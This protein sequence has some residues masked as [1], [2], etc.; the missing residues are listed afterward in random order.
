MTAYMLTAG[1]DTFSL[2]KSGDTVDGKGGNDFITTG[3]GNY[4]I[5]LGGGADTV[6]T[7]TVAGNT[8]SIDAAYGD[9]A[10]SIG[11]GSYSYKG[12]VGTE[13]IDASRGGAGT[14]WTGDGD[15]VISVSG[16][17]ASIAHS[18]TAG[19]GRHIVSLGGAGKNTVALGDGGGQIDVNGS[20]SSDN[21][22]SVKEGDHLIRFTNGNQTISAGAGN[23]SIYYSGSVDSGGSIS[24][25]DGANLLA[26][27][28]RGGVIQT[29]NGANTVVIGSNVSDYSDTANGTAITGR[30]ADN[31]QIYG[32]TTATYLVDSGGGDDVIWMAGAN[33]AFRFSYSNTAN[34]DVLT[35]NLSSLTLSFDG[36]GRYTLINNPDGSITYYFDA[37]N[38]LTIN[39][40]APKAISSVYTLSPTTQQVTGYIGNDVIGGVIDGLVPANN[41]FKATTVVDGGA[42]TDTLVLTVQGAAAALPAAKLTA[43]EVMTVKP[44]ADL[45]A[46]SLSLFPSVTTFNLDQSGGAGGS[47]TV[48]NFAKGGVFGVTGD[49]TSVSAATYALGYAAAATAATVN[50]SGGT[51]VAG[52]TVTGT[53]VLS[54][55]V[56]VAAGEADRVG[57]FTDAATSKA[58]TI[59]AKADLTTVLATTAT[60]GLTVTGSG[61]VDL[62]GTD[63]LARLNDAITTVNAST[64]TGGG[65]RVAA[66]ASAKMVFKG[67]AGADSYT[68]G[69]ALTTGASV[70]GG[71]GIDTLIV[72]NAADVAGA[73]GAFY[74][75]FEVLQIGGTTSVDL[76]A[77]TA[78]TTFAALAVTGGTTVSAL[79]AS[80]TKITV[81]GAGAVSLTEKG[82]ALKAGL[83]I[84]AN[85]ATGAFTFD[86]TGTTTN[87]FTLIGGSASNK[88]TGGAQV[89]SVNLSK[90][91]AVSDVVALTSAVGGT[92]T[93]PNAT[94][95]GFKALAAGADSLDLLGSATV[96]ANVTNAVVG[97]NL[98]A[99]IANGVL[100]FGGSAAAAA[101]LATKINAAFS[102][103]AIG[104]T[105]HRTAAFVHA[106]DTY[107]VEQGDATAGYTAGLDVVVKLVGLTGLTSLA[108]G[109]APVSATANTLYIA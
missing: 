1:N 73:S 42:G 32:G 46:S 21:V 80:L 72:T 68:T 25:G 4:T 76:N 41:T 98:T 107:V 56:N 51:N 48:T 70:D 99:T 84:D 64:M 105:Q 101:T 91:V 34:H 15:K 7:G 53:G 50:L 86:A 10:V 11:G 63:A 65:V 16:A 6:V 96:A 60:T 55:V 77:F 75:N 45:A 83:T 24:V 87:G 31:I 44:F 40:A 71:A 104:A 3:A 43:V 90:S 36:L 14:I 79:M 18:I 58:L 81:S 35:N 39:G 37:N 62:D 52:I 57:L 85:A 93:A 54:T 27:G 67:G 8:L 38:T 74:K 78:N 12:G 5:T 69:A 61:V 13:T 109:L 94:I 92:L 23:N 9:N 19:N 28:R 100:T 66:G 82:G 29:G 17:N 49:K 103:G 95:T 108:T 33:G 59:N 106:G 22:I 30:G 26:L 2:S 102:A 47:A 88:V 89:F 97:T 20:P